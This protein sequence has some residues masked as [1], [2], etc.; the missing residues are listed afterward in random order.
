M[1]TF[2][3]SI[4]QPGAGQLMAPPFVAQ[5]YAAPALAAAPA[6]DRSA[7]RATLSAQQ[8]LDIEVGLFLLSQ[9]L[10]TASPDVLPSLLT[11][12]ASSFLER[13]TWTPRQHK[14]LNRGRMLL[15]HVRQNTVWAA[16]LDA[17]VAVPERLQ[18]YD[19]STD[20]S[21]FREKSVGFFRNRIFTLKQMVG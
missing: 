9:L 7:R 12:K 18:A 3:R 16:L 15:A 4:T 19:I 11:D 21:R 14:L 17:Y 2:F 6:N 20:R 13:P 8:L 5:P 10:P 1:N